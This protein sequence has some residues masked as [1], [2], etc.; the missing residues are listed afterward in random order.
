[1][2]VQNI[3]VPDN[4]R[5]ILIVP[6]PVFVLFMELCGDAPDEAILVKEMFSPAP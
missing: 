4:D 5:A 2:H 1:M 6:V 3:I